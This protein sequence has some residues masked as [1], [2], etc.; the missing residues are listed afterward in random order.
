MSLRPRSIRKLPNCNATDLRESTAVLATAGTRWWQGLPP[1]FFRLPPDREPCPF[2]GLSRAT[3]VRLIKPSAINGFR[4]PVR[5]AAIY[6]QGATK[7]TRLIEYGSFER[8]VHG[9]SAKARRISTAP[10]YPRWVPF[11]SQLTT[12]VC[13]LTGLNRSKLEELTSP[14][15]GYGLEPPVASM[16]MI[17]GT[18][19]KGRRFWSCLV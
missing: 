12:G 10:T 15:S 5:A 13:P 4:P 18:N 7:A 14:A 3:L 17:Q 16:R 6:V 11:P 19:A 9:F 2:S 1:L 8:H